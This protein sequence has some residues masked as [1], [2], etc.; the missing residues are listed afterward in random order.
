M[1]YTCTQVPGLSEF[2]SGENNIVE[3]WIQVRP[4]FP[5]VLIPGGSMWDSGIISLELHGKSPKIVAGPGQLLPHS[6]PFILATD[7]WMYRLAFVPAI[8]FP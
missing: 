6:P 1:G 2:I 4:G 3:P 7:I 5:L 8:P